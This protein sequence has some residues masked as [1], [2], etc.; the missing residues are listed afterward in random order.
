LKQLREK[1]GLS[2]STIKVYKNQ[3]YKKIEEYLKIYGAK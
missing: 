1:T 3:A 2:Q